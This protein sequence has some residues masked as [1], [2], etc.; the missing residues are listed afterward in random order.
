M[1]DTLPGGL[2]VVTNVPPWLNGSNRGLIQ[3]TE[4]LHI[5]TAL[6]GRPGAGRR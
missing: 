1:I 3:A 6:A 5:G 2:R 4:E